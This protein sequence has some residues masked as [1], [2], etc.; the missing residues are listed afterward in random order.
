MAKQAGKLITISIETATADTYVL[1]GGLQS[2]SIRMNAASID[3]TD[4]DSTDLFQELLAGGG[5]KSMEISGQGLFN[6]DAAVERARGL[7]LT[8]SLNK[9]K[10]FIPDWGT[11]T[12]N[13][14]ITSLEFSG[15]YDG[16][17][18]NSLSFMSSGKPTW[19]AV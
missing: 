9:F 16:P 4:G 5:V 11:A 2:K 10:F 13:F 15:S 8:G 6:D 17:V 1:F 12:G 18:T 3:V 7:F 14:H 19:T